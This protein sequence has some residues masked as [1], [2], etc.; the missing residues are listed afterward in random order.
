MQRA[1]R[2]CVGLEWKVGHQQCIG[3]AAGDAALDCL[4][5]DRI[6]IR[7]DPANDISERVPAKL[8]FT[9]EATLSRRLPEKDG[10][11]LR[12]VNIWTLFRSQLAGSPVEAY[13]YT[14]YD[15]LGRVIS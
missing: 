11:E 9:K 6:E 13:G 4:G 12:D 7:V 1:F 15:A 2:R 5:V 10:S 3:E 14:A 8:G